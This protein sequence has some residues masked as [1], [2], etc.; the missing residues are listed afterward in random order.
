MNYKIVLSESDIT[1]R[2]SKK[3]ND[4]IDD[5]IVFIISN[6]KPF[7]NVYK[8]YIKNNNI[9]ILDCM[10]YLGV[11]EDG[12]I[13]LKIQNSD[14]TNNMHCWI[15]D[16]RLE[17]DDSIGLS[18]KKIYDELK[19]PL[20]LSCTNENIKITLHISRNT[21]KTSKKTSKGI[22]KKKIIN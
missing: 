14:L 15:D 3:I 9:N 16:S 5:Q 22:S 10:G 4:L 18:G 17:P 12:Y 19:H 21:Q 8:K 7:E 2:P 1:F 20:K 13:Y 11:D 6:L